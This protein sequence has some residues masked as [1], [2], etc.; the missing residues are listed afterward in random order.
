VLEPQ[1]QA[2]IAA[3]SFNTGQ[4]APRNVMKPVGTLR[5]AIRIN[6]FFVNAIVNSAT[7]SNEN[8]EKTC[9]TGFSEKR[10]DR[11]DHGALISYHNRP[12]LCSGP[13]ASHPR[14]GGVF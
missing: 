9:Q 7:G 13:V 1:D 14:N 5:D 2:A 3:T 10:V 12:L 8:S 4:T 11:T 6:G